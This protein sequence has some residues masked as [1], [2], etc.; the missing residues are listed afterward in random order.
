MKFEGFAVMLA[1]AVALSSSVPVRA[2]DLQSCEDRERV[3]RRIDRPRDRHP[4][5]QGDSVR[6]ASGRQSA[7][8]TA[9]YCRIWRRSEEGDHCRR[10]C[11]VVFGECADGIAAFA[12]I[13]YSGNCRKRVAARPEPDDTR[14][15][16]TGAC[17]TAGRVELA[18]VRAERGA[19]QRPSDSR[20]L[21]GGC[22]QA[23]P[24]AR[25]RHFVCLSS[26][27]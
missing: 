26:S 8:G 7:L 25:R 5:V 3:Y 18:G 20:E 24:G 19:G 15:C 4:R 10:V 2:S 9:Q 16:R 13:V 12:G 23:L 14:S 22:H 1:A 11:R 21:Y 6:S 17:S 27:I